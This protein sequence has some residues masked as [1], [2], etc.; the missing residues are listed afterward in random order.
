MLIDLCCLNVAGI[1]G[2]PYAVQSVEPATGPVTGNTPVLLRGIGFTESPLVQAALPLQV[3][4]HEIKGFGIL[5]RNHAQL[6]R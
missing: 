2:P 3:E 5:Q 4:T 6:M 1:V